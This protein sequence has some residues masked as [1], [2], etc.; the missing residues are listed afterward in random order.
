MPVKK[1]LVTGCNGFVGSQL[2]HVLNQKQIPFIGLYRNNLQPQLL[3]LSFGEFYKADVRNPQSFKIHLEQTSVV[4]HLAAYA[5]SWAKNKKVYFET[6]V[7]AT[8]NILDYSIKANVEKVIV[9]SSAGAFGYSENQQII[10]ENN[11]P[12][13]FFTAYDDSKWQV[14]KLVHE[15]RKKINVISICPSR[16]FGFGPLTEANA[17]TKLILKRVNGKFPWLPGNGKSIGNYVFVHDVCQA[18]INAMHLG[19]SG[20][21]Y[22]IGGEN[23]SFLQLFDLIDQASNKKRKNIQIPFYFLLFL[24]KVHE[25][26]W[27]LIHLKPSITSKFLHRYNYNYIMSSKKA[28]L[29]LQYQSTPIL[30]AIQQTIEVFKLKK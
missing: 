25:I 10:T 15:Y 14:N 22:I 18:L 28:N 1:V 26:I 23:L 11:K 19:K 13:I 5:K 27:P 21:S 12:K 4:F 24:V 29:E 9:V 17:T 3:Q 6:N 2:C 30:N 7:I 8:K 20:E 16:I